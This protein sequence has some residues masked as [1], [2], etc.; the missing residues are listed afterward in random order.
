MSTTAMGRGASTTTGAGGVTDC[1]TLLRG[2]AIVHLILSERDGGP[3]PYAMIELGAARA[4]VVS[5]R[6]LKAAMASLPPISSDVPAR[7]LKDRVRRV[8]RHLPKSLAGDEE[9]LHQLRVWARRLRAGL[10]VLAR[11]PAGKR[12]RRSLKILR[13]MQRTAGASRDLDVMVTLL[14]AR[15]QELR[16]HPAPLKLLRVRLRAARGRSRRRMAEGMLDLEIARLRRD[17]R[18]VVSRRA[19]ARFTVLLRLREARDVQGAVALAALAK[20]QDEFDPEALHR[21]RIVV[22]RLRYLAE[23]LDGVR[24]HESDAPALLRQL[25][26]ALGQLHDAYLVAQWAGVQATRAAGKGQA[27]LSAEAA[28]LHEHFLEKS[29]AQHRALLAS[30]PV[31]I[32]NRAL[33]AM[34]RA[35]VVA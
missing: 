13:Q 4:P 19:D 33:A 22:R 20:L 14:E 30:Q 11:K 8:F 1:S 10:P 12:V 34:G 18:A 15:M 28:A 31:E 32:M 24:G 35:R 27:E 25:Q 2:L 29:R 26:D 17:L 9:A 6:A 5:S 3:H 16:V 23:L 7:L 21:L